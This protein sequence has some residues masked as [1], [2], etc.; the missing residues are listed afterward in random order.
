MRQKLQTLLFALVAMMMP[1]GAWAQAQEQYQVRLYSG[2]A[3]LYLHMDVQLEGGHTK[4]YVVTDVIINEDG[5]VQLV[6]EELPNGEIPALTAVILRNDDYENTAILNVISDLE[7][8]IAEENNLLMGVLVPTAMDVS[9]GTGNFV[10][11][12]DVSADSE[13]PNLTDWQAHPNNGSWTYTLQANKAFLDLSGKL[14][15]SKIAELEALPHLQHTHGGCEICG[16]KTEAPEASW[17]TSADALTSYGTLD[18]A[19]AAAAEE[20]VG[21]I[22]LLSDIAN[23]NGYSISGGKFTL[24]LNGY[25]LVS[26]SNP[27][28]IEG[29]CNVTIT[30]GSENKTGMMSSISPDC[31]GII[32]YDDDGVLTIN[33]GKYEVVN[34][35]VVEINAGSLTITGGEFAVTSDAEQIIANNEGGTLSITGGTFD[36]KQTIYALSSFGTTTVS[37]GTFKNATEADVF[38]QSGHLTFDNDPRGVSIEYW[39]EENNIFLPD[40]Y[41]IYN[42]Y[43]EPQSELVTN[44]VYYIGKTGGAGYTVTFSANYDTEATMYDAIVTSPTGRYTLPECDFNAPEGMM[45]DGWQ[46]GDDEENLY[47]PGEEIPVTADTE[48]KAVWTEFVPQ[49]I[50][51]MHD[52]CNDGWHGDAIVV[53]K[54]GE[55]IGTA[56][57]EIED[58]ADGIVR[59]E[60]DNTAEYTFYWSCNHEQE[61]EENPEY[62]CYPNECS[63]EILVDDE[64]VFAAVRDE[65]EDTSDCQS[66]EDGE[67][68]H[69]IEAKEAV[70]LESLTINDGALTEYKNYVFTTVGTLTY[71]RT[72]PNL[73]WNALYV[74]FE[75]PVSELAE[76]YDVAYINDVHSYDTDDDGEIDDLQMEVIKITTGKLWANY[77]YLIRA[78]NVDAKEMNLELTDATLRAT[79]ENTVT[80]TSVFMQF[81]V[82]GTYNIM[83]QEDYPEIL[84]ISTDGAWKKL[85]EDTALKPFRLYLTLTALDGSPVVVEEEALTRMRIVTRGEEGDVTGIEDAQFTIDNSE[86]KIYDL[87]GRRVKTPAKGGVYIINGKKVVF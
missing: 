13:W 47:Q 82:T 31:C 16:Q 53:K 83:S 7:P 85:A 28:I 71:T 67:L 84:A 66:Y 32:L 87:S 70:E 72:L 42:E 24:D 35:C 80:C 86:M 6:E 12:W 21:Y 76:N 61:L 63:F 64:E 36:A 4:A 29:K 3:T 37:G 30:D 77:P 45:F 57:L 58:G 73:M 23:D 60:Y 54:K 2:V 49:I 14:E 5:S 43:E 1:I 10:L 17:G 55:E 68:I 78:K 50:I 52:F 38:Y 74:P 81:D 20:N 19:F 25:K 51:K 15:P 27:L 75:I 59:Y 18:E 44:E 33:G 69:T 8:F 26:S 62:C 41:G 40:G 79:K 39:A 46:V 22:Q 11:Y 34:T 65:E 56:T 9:P 48:I